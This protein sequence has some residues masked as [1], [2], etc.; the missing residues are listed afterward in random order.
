MG[1]L[2]LWMSHTD[3]VAPIGFSISGNRK[4]A[5]QIGEYGP[6]LT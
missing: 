6:A 2:Q 5:Q 1:I 3:D 4:S